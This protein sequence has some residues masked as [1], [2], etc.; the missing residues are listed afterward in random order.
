VVK[1]FLLVFIF[2]SFTAQASNFV[3][4]QLDGLCQYDKQG[5]YDKLLKGFDDSYKVMPAKR[6]QI[7]IVKNKSC[8]FPL[9]S[10]FFRAK[11]DLIQSQSVQVVHT[12]FYS[13]KKV[14]R[15]FNEVKN[16]RVGI[17]SE[18]GFSPKVWKGMSHN[19]EVKSKKLEQNVKMLLLGR[20]D[21]ILE[22]VEDMEIYFKQYPELKEKLKY[23]TSAHI[24]NFDD[25]L[26]CIDTP[27][28]R[29]LIKRFNA[30]LGENKNEVLAQP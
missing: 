1:I 10:K 26:I 17:R 8:A 30:F 29:K 9:D 11:V 3:T 22:F 27:E 16:L 21:V 7:Y 4:V 25:A 24:E 15:S 23:D 5:V 2:F 19:T 28:N 13:L 18:L 6:A 14:Y 20:S 12:V